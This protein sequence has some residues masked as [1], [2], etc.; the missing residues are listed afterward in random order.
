MVNVDIVC[1][2]RYISIWC[3]NVYTYLRL[4]LNATKWEQKTY[5][6]FSVYTFGVTTHI[7]VA[8]YSY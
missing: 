3:C 2:M 5:I 6:Y 7:V 4:N 1:S 8:A